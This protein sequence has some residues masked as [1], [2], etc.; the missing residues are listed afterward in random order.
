MNNPSRPASADSL[1]SPSAAG[2]L[3]PHQVLSDYYANES[4]R[5]QFLDDIFDK[6]SANYD[7]IESLIGF[8]SGPWYRRQALERAGLKAGMRVVDVGIGTG[9]VARQAVAIVGDPTLVTGVD[10]SAGMMSH[11]H[12]PEGVRLLQGKGESIPLPDAA[13]DFLSM[14]FALRHLSSLD[15]AF[16][17][18]HRVCKPGAR[19][20][21]L[22]I[23][24]GEGSLS[25]WLLKVYLKTIVPGIARIWSRD[26]ETARIWRYYWDT[27]EACVPPEAV[28]QAL[29]DAGF[30]DVR[31]HV[32]LGVFSEYQATRP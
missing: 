14:G 27:I 2:Q 12:L 19:I 26:A 31:R 16:R 28:L 8:G 23:T 30:T 29:R 7:R 32:E 25:G 3:L 1:A 18:F 21:L 10:P 17:E 9:L 11:A 22:E 4:S 15:A 24:R 13:T 6:T 20:C 5:R